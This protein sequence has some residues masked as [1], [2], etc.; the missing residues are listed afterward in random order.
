MSLT[1]KT[2]SVSVTAETDLSLRANTATLKASASKDVSLISETATLI[3]AAL[4]SVSINSLTSTLSL[5]SLQ[6]ASLSSMMD[7]LVSAPLGV[8]ISGGLSVDVGANKIVITAGEE[9][10]LQVG[11]SAITIK[12]DGI[13]VSG[14]KITSTAIGMHEISGALIKIN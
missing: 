12:A 10:T 7:I 1:A 2:A 3:A 8:S 4:Q 13:T 6:R 11:G 5:S 9:I 14:P